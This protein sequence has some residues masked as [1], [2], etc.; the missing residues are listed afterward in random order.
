M[1]RP[2]GDPPTVGKVALGCSARA[3]SPSSIST[4]CCLVFFCYLVCLIVRLLL[5]SYLSSIFHV[6]H[7]DAICS[8]IIQQRPLVQALRVCDILCHFTT[9]PP[10][11]ENHCKQREKKQRFHCNNSNAVKK[12]LRNKFK[13]LE[14]CHRQCKC[15]CQSNAH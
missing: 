6:L 1:N 14:L 8:I 15:N 11:V 9:C 4:D 7:R 13:R 10:R 12:S 5:S 2:G 3:R